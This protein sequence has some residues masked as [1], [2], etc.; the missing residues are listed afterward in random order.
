[1]AAQLNYAQSF[2]KQ[3]HRG[4]K[5][6][7]PENTIPAMKNALKMGITTLE[8]DLAITKDRKVIL[9]HDSFLSRNWLQNL[10][11]NIS[12]E[13]PVLLQNL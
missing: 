11:A 8:M 9:S 2:D 1:M 4:G 6:L 10:T 7:Y 13:T 3:A 12:Q 5:S